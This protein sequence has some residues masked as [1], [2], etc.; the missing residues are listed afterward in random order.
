MLQFLKY[1]F[2]FYMSPT[3]FLASVSILFH[4]KYVHLELVCLHVI[5]LD[6]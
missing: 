6:L 5:F 4:L 3:V 2:L 1:I